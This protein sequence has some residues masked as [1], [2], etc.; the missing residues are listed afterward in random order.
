[1]DHFG[2][3]QI[4]WN[5][6]FK[7]IIRKEYLIRLQTKEGEGYGFHRCRQYDLRFA[8]RFHNIEQTFPKALLTKMVEVKK[9]E[10]WLSPMTKAPRPT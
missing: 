2:S 7:N 3:V 5:I 9:E 6:F 8:S 4:R 10:I 1:M